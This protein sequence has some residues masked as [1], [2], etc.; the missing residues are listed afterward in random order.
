MPSRQMVPFLAVAAGLPGVPEA[1]QKVATE[2]LKHSLQESAA[3][4]DQK[5][6][7]NTYYPQEIA[8]GRKPMD[9]T[10]WQRENKAAG[11]QQVTID[12]KGESAFS[13]KTNQAIATRYE[14]IVEEGD[15][16]QVDLGFIGQLRALNGQFKTGGAAGLQGWLAERGVKVG[17]NIS[18]V[19]AYSSLINRLTPTQRPPGAGATSDFDAAMYKASLPRLLNT[20][21]GN[22]FIIDVMQAVAQDRIERAKIADMGQSGELTIKETNERLRGLGKNMQ[23]LNKKIENFGKTDSTEGSNIP[24]PPPGSV[25][26]EIIK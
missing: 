8:A 16:A 10:P 5:E 19:E 23:E 2:L 15:S 3:T 24:P 6:Y 25:P 11:R 26:L 17:S 13:V 20:P 12:Q 21:G 18:A 22:A 9:F 1:T 14:K 7:W 4:P